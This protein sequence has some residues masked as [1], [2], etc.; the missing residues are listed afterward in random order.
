VD[1][2]R[3]KSRDLIDRRRV[4]AAVGVLAIALPIFAILRGGD[5]DEGL[6]AV[7]STALDRG[8]DFW[9]AR[10]P[11]Y[12]RAKVVLF[13]ERTG[14]GCGV[15]ET[16]FG[17]FYC[18]ADERIYLD[19]SFLRSIRGDLARAYVIAHEL[20]HHVQ[21]LR[22]TA[23]QGVAFELE[24]DC[25]AGRW[26]ADERAHRHL[27]AGDIDAALAE[28]AAVGDDRLCPACTRDQWTHGSGEQRRRALNAGI[29]TASTC[30][31]IP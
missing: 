21:Q 25:L 24:A 2:N 7:V 13:E 23:K 8:Q 15:G 31:V 30:E 29:A 26:M 3:S 4:L 22:G 19:L 18:P 5:Q 11:H 17:P 6:V 28:A 1:L 16:A 14:T 12:R 20:G 27:A 9:S 10:V